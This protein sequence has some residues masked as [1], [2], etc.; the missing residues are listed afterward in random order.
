M[1]RTFGDEAIRIDARRDDIGLRGMISRR[2]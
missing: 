1:G 2:R